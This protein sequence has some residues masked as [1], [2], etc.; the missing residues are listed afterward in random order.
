MEKETGRGP[1]SDQSGLA[2]SSINSPI[3]Y[4]AFIR[5]LLNLVR[6]QLS[7]R[8]EALLDRVH[9]AV[10]T[11]ESA[12][13]KASG[14]KDEEESASLKARSCTLYIIHSKK[15]PIQIG[16]IHRTCVHECVCV[17]VCF[18]LV[19]LW[20]AGKTLPLKRPLHSSLRS[21][22]TLRAWL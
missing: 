14:N 10:R 15:K 13:E 18:F 3:P 21:D 4:P 1:G 8:L 20:L 22:R 6:Q 7:S 11:I 2:H 17:C 9:T 12:A 5:A 16:T 19:R